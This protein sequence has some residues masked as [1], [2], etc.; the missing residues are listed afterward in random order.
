MMKSEQLDTC[1]TGYIGPVKALRN[2]LKEKST[3]TSLILPLPKSGAI[4]LYTHG[5]HVLA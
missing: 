5:I 3:F 2:S 4:G 1:I